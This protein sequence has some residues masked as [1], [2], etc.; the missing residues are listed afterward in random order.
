MIIGGVPAA[1]ACAA[2]GAGEGTYTIR[3]GGCRFAQP[4]RNSAK[5]H[6]KYGKA[7]SF[8]SLG[9]LSFSTIV[10]ATRLESKT[11]RPLGT[12]LR[13][14]DLPRKVTPGHPLRPPAEVEARCSPAEI[15]NRRRASITLLHSV[16]LERA[17]H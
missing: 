3:V 16:R 9:I 4:A 17:E 15:V 10:G 11:C 12:M 8:T 14:I 2:A 5:L 13:A 6:H 7:L 1:E